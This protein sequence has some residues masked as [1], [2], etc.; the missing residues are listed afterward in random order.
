MFTG[1]VTRIPEHGDAFALGVI[2]LMKK[3]GGENIELNIPVPYKEGK[4]EPLN[5]LE[6]IQDPH[7][8]IY[9]G[10][11][12][13]KRSQHYPPRPLSRNVR[14][15]KKTI[16]WSKRSEDEDFTDFLPFS[17]IISHQN[18]IKPHEIFKTHL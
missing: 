1:S 8:E 2:R 14:N 3:S 9:K 16:Y 12:L 11:D 18:L 15:H 5:Q 17:T 4:R 6:D 13:S 7:N 10:L